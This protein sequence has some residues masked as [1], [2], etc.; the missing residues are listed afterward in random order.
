MACVTS[1]SSRTVALD[2]V[3]PARGYDDSRAIMRTHDAR[4]KSQRQ[5]DGDVVWNASAALSWVG[6][7]HAGRGAVRGGR[8]T[9]Q[10]LAAA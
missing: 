5:K 2:V 9:T 4:D 6:G 3:V 1:S 7:S 8:P 10:S